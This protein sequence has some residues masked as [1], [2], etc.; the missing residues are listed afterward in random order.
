MLSNFISDIGVGVGGDMA[1]VSGDTELL[2]KADGTKP[3]RD[4]GTLSD[5]MTDEIQWR[6]MQVMSLRGSTPN[7]MH[8]AMGS[9]LTATPQKKDPGLLQGI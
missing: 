6:Q 3:Q 9:E 1:R 4:L 5:K 2:G 8:M 7:I